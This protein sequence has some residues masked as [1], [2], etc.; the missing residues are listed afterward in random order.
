MCID[1]DAGDAGK[2]LAARSKLAECAVAACPALIRGDCAR[3]NADL[4]AT[5]PSSSSTRAPSHDGKSIA[6]DPGPHRLVFH[7]AGSRARAFGTTK[8]ARTTGKS[9]SQPRLGLIIGLTGLAIA[10]GGLLWHFLEPSGP[11]RSATL[12]TPWAS[13]SGGGLATSGTF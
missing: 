5:M 8:P 10:G 4:A 9:Q 2:L 7:H 3:W 12:L 6:I 13:A 11:A 1:S